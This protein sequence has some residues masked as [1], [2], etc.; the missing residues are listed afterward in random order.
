M[1]KKTYNVRELI[2]KHQANCDRITAIAD[3]CE[4]EQRERNE[5]ENKEHAQF[6]ESR[7]EAEPCVNNANIQIIPEIVFRNAAYFANI[8]RQRASSAANCAFR[9]SSESK[10]RSSRILVMTRTRR[11]SP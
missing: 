6:G 9:P 3:V 1:S 10:R 2:N 4:R 8:E 11:S 5:A 7:L